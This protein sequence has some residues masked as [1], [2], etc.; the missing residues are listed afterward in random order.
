MKCFNNKMYHCSYCSKFCL[1]QPQPECGHRDF[2]CREIRECILLSQTCDRHQH[3]KD[4]S[5]EDDCDGGCGDWGFQCNDGKCIHKRQRCD[6]VTGDCLEYEDE[7]G[8]GM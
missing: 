2:Q 7:M 5:D 6:G 3:C 8:C 1:F 4:G